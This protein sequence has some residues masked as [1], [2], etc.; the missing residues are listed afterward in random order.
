M[1]PDKTDPRNSGDPLFPFEETPWR[2]MLARCLKKQ[3]GDTLLETPGNGCLHAPHL[4]RGDMLT[5]VRNRL[6]T[7]TNPVPLNSPMGYRAIIRWYMAKISLAYQTASSVRWLTAPLHDGDLTDPSPRGVALWALS[8][9]QRVVS[10]VAT[11]AGDWVLLDYNTGLA[12]RAN[13]VGQVQWAAFHD[14]PGLVDQLRAHPSNVLRRWVADLY[15]L[16]VDLPP[17]GVGP[18]DDDL[19]SPPS[20]D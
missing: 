19:F 14:V 8:A 5:Q 4:I 10:M 12:W 3:P 17:A 15:S 13:Y 6:W 7:P 16:G 11:R 1:G 2:P 20:F 9:Q 18:R